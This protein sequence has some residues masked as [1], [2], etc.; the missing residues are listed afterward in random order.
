MRKVVAVGVVPV[1]AAP[2]VVVV[3]A[4]RLTVRRIGP[5]RQPPRLNALEDPK[6]LEGLSFEGV[7]GAMTFRPEDQS[8]GGG[9]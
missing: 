5:V 8:G 3:D 2:T 4:P 9:R 7:K 1:D 6:A